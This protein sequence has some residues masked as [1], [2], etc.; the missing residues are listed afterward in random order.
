V[1]VVD[2][3]IRGVVLGMLHAN[4]SGAG[5]TRGFSISMPNTFAMSPGYVRKYIQ[6]HAL[7]RPDVDVIEMLRSKI[8]RY[9]LG[10]SPLLG[11]EAWEQDATLPYPK[12]LQESKVKLLLTSPPYLQVIKYGKYNWVRLWFLGK[13]SKQVDSQLMASA[14]LT[15]YLEFIDATLQQARSALAPDG[16]ICLVIGDVRRKNEDLNLA[17]EVWENVGRKH[18]R[19]P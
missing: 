6:D 5:A 18:G 9:G 4:H 12:M 1:E 8:L 15:K 2:E 10:E 3:F 17:Q 16:V 11:G 13:D 14:S 7:I 19:L